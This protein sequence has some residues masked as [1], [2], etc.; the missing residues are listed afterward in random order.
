MNR[1]RR[2]G[3]DGTRTGAAL[4]EQMRYV[5]R[6][7]GAVRRNVTAKFGPASAQKI[8]D[9]EHDPPGRRAESQ[10]QPRISS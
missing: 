9:F 7:M 4:R 8:T 3:A 5:L 6:S 2:Y 1:G 10:V